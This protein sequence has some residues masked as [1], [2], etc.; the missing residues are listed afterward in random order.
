L[1]AQGHPRAIYQRI[2]ISQLDRSKIA[3]EVM[4]NIKELLCLG[5]ESASSVLSA[6]ASGATRFFGR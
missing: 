4:Q 2:I 3:P 6:S 5:A 1:T